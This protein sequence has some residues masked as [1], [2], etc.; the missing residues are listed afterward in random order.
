MSKFSASSSGST[1]VGAGRGREPLH[2][3]CLHPSE[4]SVIV[5]SLSRL[6]WIDLETKSPLRIFQGGHVGVVS[7][8]KTLQVGQQCYVL[9]AGD[10]SQDYTIT[11]WKLSL[12]DLTDITQKTKNKL[13]AIQ[14]TSDSI[15]AKFSVNESVRSLIVLQ[16]PTD[17]LSQGDQSVKPKNQ[18]SE[19]IFGAITKTGT[20]HCFKHD[21]LPSRKKKPIKPT[22]SLQVS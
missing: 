8:L 4:K 11:V 13:P 20:F 3:I 9:S 7:S 14:E 10:S 21:F 16:L 18:A 22:V 15:V 19:R 2:S 1:A 12:D 6:T 17:K 5:G